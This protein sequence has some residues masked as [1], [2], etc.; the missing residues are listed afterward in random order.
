[1][2]P[3]QLRRR[4]WT[5]KTGDIKLDK[6]V[7]T[8][9]IEIEKFDLDHTLRGAGG[10]G[11]RGDI[12]DFFEGDDDELAPTESDLSHV[13]K[14]ADRDRNPIEIFS[15]Q[16]PM[17]NLANLGLRIRMLQ[18]CQIYKLLLILLVVFLCYLA[19]YLWFDLKLDEAYD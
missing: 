18:R 12:S 5:I 3:T 6:N 11:K 17:F 2:L 1:M 16:D 14:R 7:M 9:T 19:I 10:G 13:I 4:S 15:G 8:S